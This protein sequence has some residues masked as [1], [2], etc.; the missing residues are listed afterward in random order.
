MFASKVIISEE[1]KKQNQLSKR[2]QGKLRYERMVELDRTG[3]LS[4]ASTRNEVA[5]MLGFPSN[6][7]TGISW[8]NN[9]V[10]RGYLAETLVGYEGG[11]MRKEF[12]TTNKQPDYDFKRLKE[13]TKRAR[14]ERKAKQIEIEKK[15]EE[16]KQ[17][18]TL[19]ITKGDMTISTTLD[20][21]DIVNVIINILTK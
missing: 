3:K 13:A 16:D 18:A 1:T 9:Q 2:Q 7:K 19:T 10:N 21:R 15:I 6:S 11:K 20:G 17:S 4:E 14:A 12:H 5:V 8:V